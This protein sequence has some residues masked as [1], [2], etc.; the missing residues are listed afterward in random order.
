ME[1]CKQVTFTQN[2]IFKLTSKIF[3]YYPKLWLKRMNFF[4]LIVNNIQIPINYSLFSCICDK[5]QESKEQENQLSIDS[6]SDNLK[7]FFSFFDL[8]KGYSFPFHDF[9]SQNLQCL[10]DCF[11][12][13][14]LLFVFGQEVSVSQ[15]LEESLKHLENENKNLEHRNIQIE[16]EKNKLHNLQN[17]SH[18]EIQELHY[19]NEKLLEENKQLK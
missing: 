16:K 3:I 12:I 13:N 8:M 4:H 5:F 11:V 1:Q 6:D 18:Q 10:H 9:T 17:K 14:S 2:Q 15:T 7:C 19:E